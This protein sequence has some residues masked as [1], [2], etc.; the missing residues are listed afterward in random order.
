MLTIEIR[1]I[2][3]T[4]KHF[5]FRPQPALDEIWR[6]PV[7]KLPKPG[8]VF[9]IDAGPNGLHRAIR[10]NVVFGVRCYCLYISTLIELINLI[11]SY[12]IYRN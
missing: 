2:L 8:E 4:E 11:F 7:K 9:G 12:I 1:V 6:T 10:N 5:I 3:L